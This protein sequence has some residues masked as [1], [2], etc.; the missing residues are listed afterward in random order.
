MFDFRI[1]RPEYCEPEGQRAWIDVQTAYEGR[2]KKTVERDS[3]Q[4]ALDNIESLREVY[5]DQY[6]LEGKVLDVGGHR[7]LLRHYLDNDVS[8]Y[9]SVDPY[10]DVFAG[11]EQH[12]MLLRAYPSL[13]KP[14]NFVAA[15][16][17]YLPFKA[18][19]F[20]WVHMRN[21]VDHFADPYM[22]FLEAYRCSRAG[23]RLLVGLEIMEKA[24]NPSKTSLHARVSRRLKKTGPL[25]LIRAV[26]KRLRALVSHGQAP[27]R[28]DGHMFR[29]TYSEL[30]DLFTK[31]GWQVVKQYWRRPPSDHI[32]YA[33]GRKTQ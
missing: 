17:E 1:H 32:I 15:S 28:T 11:I 9:V 7:G 2:H 27:N 30:M 5:S 29:L 22:A 26:S 19:S 10:I 14:C 31:T 12:P 23:G 25:G 3:L 13:S 24:N 16:A 33:C 20:D 21:V 18:G 8:L 6:H 4:R